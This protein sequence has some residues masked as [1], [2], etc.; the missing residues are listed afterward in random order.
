[1]A[2]VLIA[3][4]VSPAALADLQ[5]DGNSIRYEPSFTTADLVSNISSYQVLV[6]RSTKVTGAVFASAT[7]L[8]LIVR[9][10]AGV[11]TIDVEAASRSGVLVCNTPGCNS[12]AVAE[13]AIGHIIACDRQIV[14]NS[15]QL[16]SGRWVKGRYLNC[17]GLNGRTLGVIGAGA[18]AQRVIRVGQ[19]MGMRVVCCAPE[20]DASLASRL[21]VVRAADKFEVARS[22]DAISVHIPLLKQTFHYFGREFFEAM[23]AGAIFVNTSRGEV[24]DTTA[25]VEAIQ[26][27]GLR[28]GLDVYEDEPS[29]GSGPFG[30]TELAKLL[31]S[32]TCHI[33]GSTE[34][35]SEAVA[36]ETIN[37][38][39]TWLRT[40]EALHCVNVEARQN[41]VGKAEVGLLELK[42]KMVVEPN[43]ETA[44][45]ALAS[46]PCA[47]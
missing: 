18:I 17:P 3:D 26:T 25:L 6:V 35:A 46:L 31:S 12:D 41:E 4:T 39:R 30:G 36:A 27:K 8:E 40:G 33:G 20:L 7:N 29:G 2:T 47:T 11:D 5:R 45:Q 15:S 43:L 23:K 22:S 21:G 13:L 1:M 42:G 38:V 34:Q 9:A 16:R 37:V 14:N 28:V 19:A 32:C 10:G 24:V 44:G